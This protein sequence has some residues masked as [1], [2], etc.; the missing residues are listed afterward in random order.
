MEMEQEV[1]LEEETK[2]SDD[3]FLDSEEVS[4][5]IAVQHDETSPSVRSKKRKNRSDE[6]F[7]KAVGLITESLK[8]ISKDLSEGIKFDMN[9]NE[10]SEKI[11][12]V[13]LKMNSI[14]QLEKF[15]A[16]TKIRSDPITV[17]NFWEIE[18][19]DIEAWVKYILEG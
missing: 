6:G 18:E 11:P 13:I 10:L 17:Q 8:E 4:R 5:T 3:D 15:K 16:L 14:S 12:S 9:I 2:D 19:G 7:N 1:N